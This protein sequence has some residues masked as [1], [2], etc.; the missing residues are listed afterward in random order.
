MVLKNPSRTSWENG[1]NS[2]PLGLLMFCVVKDTHVR[3]QGG[4]EKRKKGVPRR[5]KGGA[6]KRNCTVGQLYLV[7][8]KG[9]SFG[10]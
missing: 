6:E 7:C 4:T 1:K 2:L 5:E 8:S 9:S 10:L 3:E